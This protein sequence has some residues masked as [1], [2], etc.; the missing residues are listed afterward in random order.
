MGV[1]ETS[2]VQDREAKMWEQ[3]LTEVESRQIGDSSP[4]ERTGTRRNIKS[5][6]AQ[7][8]A[9]GGKNLHALGVIFS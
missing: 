3:N 8:I 7:M 6:H 2:Q 1:D 4:L 5:R 9:I